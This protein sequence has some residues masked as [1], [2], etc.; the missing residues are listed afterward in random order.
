MIQTAK[1]PLTP[2]H[3]DIILDSIADGVFTVDEH[4]KI[5]YFNRAAERITRIPR[6]KA[7]GQYC[8]DVLRANICEKSC[9]LRCSLQSNAAVVDR[10]VNILR[11]DGKQ[12][13][14]TISTS[15]LRDETGKKIGGV[16]TFRDL[17]PLEELK[18]EIKCAYTLD[19]IISKN[20]RIQGIFD[21]L[22]NIAESE[23]TVLIQGPS[24]SGKELFSRAIHNASL[25]ATG[26]FIAVN[27]GALPD[28][29]LES[30]LFGYVKGAFTDAKKDKPGRFALAKGGSIFLDEIESLSL[31]MQVKLL[32]VLQEK[33]FEPLGAIVPVKADARV[34]AASKE[35]LS[36]LVEKGTFRDDLFF[37]LNVVK[38]ILPPLQER[39]EDIPLLVDHFIEKFNSKMTRMISGISSQVLQLLIT[40]DF[41]GNV[42]ELENIIEHAFVMCREDEIQLHH[43]PLELLGKT[44]HS[45][46]PLAQ[47][48]PLQ[49]AERAKILDA[50]TEHQW[51]K[52][53]TARNL[54]VHRATLYRKIKKFALEKR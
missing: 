41:P 53:E 3:T 40:Y 29:L 11:I 48:S 47:L 38:L 46:Y 24:G 6:E 44:V 39:R 28:T 31:A 1:H 25:R 12:I 20:H 43:L 35:D 10:R 2:L 15:V 52:I 4:M 8:F 30:E 18:K 21:I 19:D 42:R 9:P 7:I 22:P 23:S 34:I 33:E 27:C 16:E 17:S 49:E 50:L 32:R 13:P 54:G 5:T 37:R 36:V 51:N 45:D 14:V 26:P